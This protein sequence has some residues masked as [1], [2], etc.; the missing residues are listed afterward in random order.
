MNTITNF[1]KC[2]LNTLFIKSMNIA[3]ALVNQNASTNSKCPYLV[4]N[5]VLEIYD[6]PVF[7]LDDRHVVI[8]LETNLLLEVDQ[9]DHQSY[10]PTPLV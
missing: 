1:S 3:R 6:N 4:S 8:N 9:V 2:G 7:A 5:V 10:H